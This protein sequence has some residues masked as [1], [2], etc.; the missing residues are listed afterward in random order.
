[1]CSSSHAGSEVC[2]ERT[3][4]EMCVSAMIRA[5]LSSLSDLGV[6]LWTERIG[7]TVWTPGRDLLMP[8]KKPQSQLQSTYLCIFFYFD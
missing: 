7:D 4:V 3:T 2:A 5:D 6:D 8:K 1:M